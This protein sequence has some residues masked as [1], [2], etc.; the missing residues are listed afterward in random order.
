M[1]N[2]GIDPIFAKNLICG[3]IRGLVGRS[4]VMVVWP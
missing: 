1:N 3:I 2:K 4:E